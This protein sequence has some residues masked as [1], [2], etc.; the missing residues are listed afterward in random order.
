MTTHSSRLRRYILKTASCLAFTLA[1][2]FGVSTATADETYRLK[3]HTYVPLG[4]PPMQHLILP[5]AEEL[6]KKSDG[7]LKIDVYPM[8]QLGG[9]QPQLIEQVKDGVVDMVWTILGAT[10]G[11]FVRSE[12]FELPF[13]HRNTT[14]TNLAL[15]EMLSNELAADFPDF[16]TL[17]LHV[18]AG[19]A[20]H[21][22]DTPLETLEDFKNKKIRSP[23]QTS[24]EFLS[25]V[26]MSP[27]ATTLTDISSMMSRG[28]LDGA[29]LPFDVLPAIKLYDM[30][31][32]HVMM[33][34]DR[35][36]TTAIFMLAINP[37][38]YEKLPEDLRA[39]IDTSMTE[40][41]AVKAAEVF[42]RFDQLGIDLVSKGDG[43]IITLSPK[44]T[45]RVIKAS[46]P[47]VERWRQRIKDSGGDADKLLQRSHDLSEKYTKKGSDNS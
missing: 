14:A 43:Q 7:R 39:L 37:K 47:V 1:T 23:G 19:N 32:Y 17:M 11:R 10:P 8:M 13:V 34:Q 15:R 42:D 44:E 28:V 35:R 9:R 12:V 22:R 46:E 36:P 16:K 24:T 41:M 26:D 33:D 31:D 3:L 45:E 18:H 29:M 6:N 21:M 25:A 27:I 30:V 20:L 4:V 38:S 2:G 5:W 40:E